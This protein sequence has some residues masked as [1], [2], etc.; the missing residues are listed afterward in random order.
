MLNSCLFPASYHH[1]PLLSLPLTANVENR[2]MR[3]GKTETGDGGRPGWRGGEPA[4]NP[5][6]S[7]MWERR[8]RLPLPPLSLAT[9]WSLPLLLSSTATTSWR[10]SQL[11]M[12]ST[13][14]T[15]LAHPTSLVWPRPWD[16]LLLLTHLPLQSE[17]D[18]L[19][20][21]ESEDE[22]SLVLS[23]L[24]PPPPTP[25][26]S[27]PPP[28]L[29]MQRQ[30]PLTSPPPPTVGLPS[31]AATSTTISSPALPLPPATLDSSAPT[32]PS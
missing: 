23:P 8:Q 5:T 2:S 17:L 32:V 4:L 20:D 21:N 19:R 10:V 28:S 12:P 16:P 30:P 31:P 18:L 9:L 26:P 7:T 22:N 13:T 15:S 11:P 25:I 24:C 1:Q 27:S 14:T 6:P 29:Q 3:G